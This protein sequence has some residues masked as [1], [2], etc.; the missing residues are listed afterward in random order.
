MNAGRAT[1]RRQG[2]PYTLTPT[3]LSLAAMLTSG[4]MTNRLDRLE[5]RG[6]VRREP[7]PDDRRGVRVVLTSAGLELV[8]RAIEARFKEAAHAVEGLSGQER[9]TL[10][11]LL[12]QLLLG[13]R[14]DVSEA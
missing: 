2:P 8:D 11:S 12:R 10:E 7:D 5:T 9:E 14:E 1:L 13:V 4:A 3:E 6:L